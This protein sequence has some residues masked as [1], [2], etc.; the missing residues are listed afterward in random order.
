MDKSERSICVTC[1]SRYFRLPSEAII[2]V[3][4]IIMNSRMSS[5]PRWLRDESV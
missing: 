4:T 3:K 5:I 2:K 1:G